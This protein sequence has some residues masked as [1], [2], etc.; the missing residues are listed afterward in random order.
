M[1]KTLILFVWGLL[2]FT[3]CNGVLQ[4]SYLKVDDSL[5]NIQRNSVVQTSDEYQKDV[6]YFLFVDRFFDGNP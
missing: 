3:G 5:K 4:S 6:I 1:K 2:L